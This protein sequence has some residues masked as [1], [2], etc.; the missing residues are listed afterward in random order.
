MCLSIVQYCYWTSFNVVQCCV[1]IEPF[2]YTLLGINLSSSSFDMMAKH[3]QLVIRR[4]INEQFRVFFFH[5]QSLSW[6]HPLTNLSLRTQSLPFLC[7]PWLKL[8]VLSRAL[9]FQRAII[10][11]GK[12]NPKMT[13]LDT[14]GLK[15]HLD[16]WRLRMLEESRF[17]TWT[18]IYRYFPLGRNHVNFSFPNKQFEAI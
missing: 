9:P 2:D 14:S 11:Y 3:F 13:I 18:S 5:S 16:T 8:S 12:A 1:L 17:Y 6:H 4:K 10:Q 15:A 7:P